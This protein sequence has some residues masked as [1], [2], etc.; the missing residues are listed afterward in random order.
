VNNCPAAG[1][2][3]AYMGKKLVGFNHFMKKHG[4]TL[5]DPA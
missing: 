5:K 4:I 3:H 2:R 1:N